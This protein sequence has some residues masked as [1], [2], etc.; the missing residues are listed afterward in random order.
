M[1]ERLKEIRTDIPIEILYRLLE[2]HE[3]NMKCLIMSNWHEL[4]KF[5]KEEEKILWKYFYSDL[6]G[7]V[8]RPSIN[9]IK[10]QILII[11]RD[12]KIEKL[13]K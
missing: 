5:Y 7:K 2:I 4:D 8:T 10:S 1:F 13:I 11:S 6:D 9:D 3:W 12:N